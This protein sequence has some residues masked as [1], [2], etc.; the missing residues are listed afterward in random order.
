MITLLM[1]WADAKFHVSAFSIYS[2]AF[3]VIDHN[4]LLTCLSSCFGIHGTALNWF[5]Y[6]LASHCFRV[7]CNNNFSSLHTCLYGVPEGS[8]LGPLLFVI[9]TT[10][11]S[12]LIS[13]LSLNH[14]LYADDTQRFHSI[15]QNS[16][17]ISLTCKMLY[18][19]SLPGWLQVF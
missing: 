2:T 16:T 19:R 11:L 5:R 13:S 12:T 1:L 7:K 4:N 17:L 18:N 8:V 14:H 3:G 15:H 10:L 6:Y 9:Y